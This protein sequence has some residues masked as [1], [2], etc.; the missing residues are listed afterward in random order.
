MIKR[1]F[2]I[3]RSEFNDLVQKNKSAD[4]PLPEPDFFETR[5]EESDPL[6]KYY[7]NLEIPVGS[8]RDTIKTAWKTQMKK[9]HPDLHGS[10][11]KKKQ[12]AEELTRQLNEAYRILDSAF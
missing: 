9:Y 7:A 12:I 3:A 5:Q 4:A 6:A 2:N 11:P 1:L 10:D 8:D